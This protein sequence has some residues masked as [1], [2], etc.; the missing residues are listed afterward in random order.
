MAEDD[1]ILKADPDLKKDSKKQVK[2]QHILIAIGIVT[3][4]VTFLYL[5]NKSSTS[6]ATSSAAGAI[7]PNTGLPY[8]EELANA[9]A[10]SLYGS[11]GYGGAIGPNGD[12]VDANGVDLSSGLQAA[13]SN[14]SSLTQQLSAAEQQEQTDAAAWASQAASLNT[15]ISALQASDASL[16]TA[17]AAMKSKVSESKSTTGTSSLHAIS[18]KG[19]T[20]TPSTETS[21]YAGVGSPTTA[22]NLEHAGVTLYRDITGKFVVASSSAGKS[23]AKSHPGLYVKQ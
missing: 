12:L 14:I 20:F 9:Q 23:A 15:D 2:S 17:L 13:N 18:L 1:H 7:D 19:V 10:A 22:T 5:R 3:L 11:S 21:G 16:N 8:S 6:A 4:I